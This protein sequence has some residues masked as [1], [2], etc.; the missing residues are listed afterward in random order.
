MYAYLVV[1]N[2]TQ[3]NLA[4]TSVDILMKAP[5]EMK[6]VP[7]LDENGQEIKDADGNTVMETVYTYSFDR[8]SPEY[9]YKVVVGGDVSDDQF[10]YDDL[11]VE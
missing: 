10:S 7:K 3:L 6:E 9:S 5:L 2:G 1:E 11:V 8:L 4:G